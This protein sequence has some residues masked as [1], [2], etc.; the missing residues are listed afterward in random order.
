VSVVLTIL[1]AATVKIVA[2]ARNWSCV[3]CRSTRSTLHMT[4]VFAMTYHERVM[5]KTQKRK[6]RCR[7]IDD[8]A[9]LQMHPCFNYGRRI[10]VTAKS[11]SMNFLNFIP[12]ASRLFRSSIWP[13]RLM[14]TAQSSW[15]IGELPAICSRRYVPSSVMRRGWGCDIHCLHSIHNVVPCYDEVILH[16][17]SCH[18]EQVGIS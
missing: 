10:Y 8:H 2:S 14:M 4:K 11:G 18:D 1:H 12:V 15:L 9:A 3:D 13:R 5:K 7:I 6:I 17:M 16:N